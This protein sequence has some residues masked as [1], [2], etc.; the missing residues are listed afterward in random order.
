[1]V[2]FIT[3][4]KKFEVQGEKTG[5]TYI[6]VPEEIAQQLMPGNRKSFRVKGRL[7]GHKI[8]RTALLPM[9]GGSFLIPLNAAIRKYIRKGKGEMLTVELD[10]D[11]AT[12]QISPELLQCLSDEPEALSFFRKL[13]PSHQQYFSKWIESAKTI[14]TKTRR[15]VIAVTACARKQSYGEMMRSIKDENWQ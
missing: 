3:A 9:G 15:I 13:P 4:I 7:D 6:E 2:K 14:Q 11:R 5:W 8:E 1:V 10:V 12:L